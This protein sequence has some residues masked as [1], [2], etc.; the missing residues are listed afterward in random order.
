MGP[1]SRSPSVK[2]HS[3]DQAGI[4]AGGTR[5]DFQ[6]HYGR[7]IGTIDRQVAWPLTLEGVVA[8][9]VTHMVAEARSRSY[10]RLSLE[11]GSMDAF[12]PARAL[13]ARFGFISCGPF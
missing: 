9:L 1:L 6:R 5:G 8:G 10:Q 2:S 12:A 7:S 4:D 3:G 13:Y 11:T